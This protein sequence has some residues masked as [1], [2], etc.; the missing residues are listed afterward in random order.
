MDVVPR[1]FSLKEMETPEDSQANNQ[2]GSE[3]VG[4]RLSWKTDLL[5]QAGKIH[6]AQQFFKSV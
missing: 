3:V 6:T 2:E 5:F 1:E 4:S